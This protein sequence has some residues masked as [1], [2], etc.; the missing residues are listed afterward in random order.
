MVNSS[1]SGGVLGI[2]IDG[3]LSGKSC[4]AVSFLYT[5]ILSLE[6]SG[7]AEQLS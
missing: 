7:G 6:K 3:R 5:K 2:F 1:G 4:I